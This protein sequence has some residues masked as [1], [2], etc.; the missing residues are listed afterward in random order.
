MG[1]LKNRIPPSFHHPTPPPPPVRERK[2][3]RDEDGPSV[4][5][6]FVVVAASA[7]NTNTSYPIDFTDRREQR[8]AAQDSG[9]VL[10]T[11]CSAWLSTIS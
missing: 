5:R 2:R 8:R 4:L 3:E 7:M 6:T 1:V 9:E 11:C 10:V